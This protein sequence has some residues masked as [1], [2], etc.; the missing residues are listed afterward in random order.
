M[1]RDSR[2]SV[3]EGA[4]S[5]GK[6]EGG[7]KG[8]KDGN[9]FGLIFGPGVAIVLLTEA[10]VALCVALC[11]ANVVHLRLVAWSIHLNQS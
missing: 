6:D 4:I 2:P 5:I 7:K 10:H 1:R 3:Q 8:G 11:H 9:V